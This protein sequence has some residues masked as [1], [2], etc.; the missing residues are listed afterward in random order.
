[1]ELSRKLLAHRWM[2]V[3]MV[4]LFL[5]GLLAGWIA[6]KTGGDLANLKIGWDAA[7]VYLKQNP[8][9]L[10]AA[11]V[12]LPGLPIPTSVLLATAGVVWQDKP[13]V[14][15]SLCLL[16]LAL[17]FTWTYWLAAYPARRLVEKMLVRTSI[18]IPDLPRGDYL[19]LILLLRLTPGIPL[20]LQNYLLGFLR[21]P[22]V[23][24]LPVSMLCTGVIGIGVVL[25]AAGVADGNLKWAVTGVS[26]IVLGGV[27]THLV[28][29]WLAKK[30]LRV[31]GS[32][33]L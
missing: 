18:Q 23:L 28:R 33:E 12:V 7:L 32:A 24:Y 11:L 22:F 21:A 29:G 6:W 5:V 15:C 26:L 27:L 2:R 30:K 14:A 16:A 8:W 3:G 1:M 20:F 10:F 25:S 13:V 9:A 19:K 4:G 31:E 17:N